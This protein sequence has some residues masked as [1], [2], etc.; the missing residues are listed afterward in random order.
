MLSSFNSNNPL[1]PVSP[2][3]AKTDHFD[4][5]DIEKLA[6]QSDSVKIDEWR[7]IQR[8]IHHQNTLVS[9]LSQS[10]RYRSSIIK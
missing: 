2:R 4:F 5:Q 3:M 9:W 7:S 1:P 10:C 8:P 6:V